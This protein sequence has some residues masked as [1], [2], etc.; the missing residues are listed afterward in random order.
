MAV[1]LIHTPLVFNGVVF[2]ANDKRP[3]FWRDK[4][5]WLVLTGEEYFHDPAD[6]YWALPYFL[7]TFMRGDFHD[8]FVRIY[9]TEADAVE[10]FHNAYRL[11][12]VMMKSRVHDGGSYR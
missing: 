4:W 6:D 9:D 3:F 2:T 10:D 1:D 12:V 8:K 11:V 7:H 5:R